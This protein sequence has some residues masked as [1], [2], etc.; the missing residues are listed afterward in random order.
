MHVSFLVSL[1]LAA[2]L[3][4]APSVK[5]SPTA[6]V[7]NHQQGNSA[8]PASQTLAVTAASGVPS[9]MVYTNSGSSQWLAYT[10]QFGKTALSIKVSVNPTSL[11]IGQYTESIVL[12]TP[13]TGGDSIVVPITLNVRAA[14]SDLK[15]SPTTISIA[16]RLGENPPPPVASYL[17]TTNGLLSFSAAVAGAKWLRATPASGAVFPGFRTTL[18]LNIDVTDLAPGTQKGSI[19][20]TSPDAITKTTS[21]TVNLTIQPGIPVV[22]SIWPPRLINGASDSTI[23]L[24]GDRFFSGTIV[25]S[26]NAVLKTAILGPSVLNVVVPAG[27]LAL[28]GNVPIVV[29]N[30][31]PGGGSS[32]AVTLE[33]LPPGPLLLSVV[34]AASQLQSAIAPGMVTTLYGSGLGHDVLTT[35]DGSTPYLPTTL[36]GTRVL[37]NNEAMPIIY[38]SARQVSVV[39]PNALEPNRAFMLEVEYQGIKSVVLPVVTSIA[40]P[41]L[42]TANGSGTGNAA[43]F[44]VDPATGDV[45]LNSDKN[46]ATKGSVLVLYATG[47]A[48]RLPV[49]P[50][51][52]VAVAPSGNSIDGISVMLGDVA[53]EVL[54]AGYSPGLVTGIVQINA[55]VPEITPIGKAVPVTLKI[56]NTTSASGVTLNIK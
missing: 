23:T 14:P 52:F 16:Y 11:P 37:L 7:F 2:G 29:T 53:A 26:G 47:I 49:P 34:N 31:D 46:S 41:A 15:V 28:P 35:Y 18:T 48:P 39:A 4:A 25:K 20:V 3:S 24:T 27:L 9:T 50:D 54:Y 43:A 38:A 32:G 56:N 6:L 13:D 55:R 1:F 10:P 5:V 45:S 22:S 8:I 21:I 19:T 40:A 51:G 12:I 44:Q 36:G 30:P 17:T 33:V 42:F